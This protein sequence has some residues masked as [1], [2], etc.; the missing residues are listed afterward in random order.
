MPSVGFWF[1]IVVDPVPLCK[2]LILHQIINLSEMRLEV[3][4]SCVCALG[5]WQEVGWGIANVYT[6]SIEYHNLQ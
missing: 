1:S 5:S 4:M 6:I 3:C 2:F